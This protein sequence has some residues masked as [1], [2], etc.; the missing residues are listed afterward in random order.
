MEKLHVDWLSA[1][2]IFFFFGGGGG[3]D[4]CFFKR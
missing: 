3:I 2:R 1:G 4:Y